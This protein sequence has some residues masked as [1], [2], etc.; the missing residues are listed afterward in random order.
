VTRVPNFC[1]KATDTWNSAR[2]PACTL[3]D[4]S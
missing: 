1:P 3:Q 4:G 2:H